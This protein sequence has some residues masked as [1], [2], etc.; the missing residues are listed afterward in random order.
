ME[1]RLARQPQIAV[2]VRSAEVIGPAR[3]RGLTLE[4]LRDQISR[5]GNTPYELAD[6]K[7]EAH[8]SVFVPSSLLNRMRREAVELLQQDS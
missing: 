2:T 4:T 7:L 5:L 6:L 8:G 1:W 3:N